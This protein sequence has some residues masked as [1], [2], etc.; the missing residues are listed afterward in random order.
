VLYWLQD[1]PR[2]YRATPNGMV[3]QEQNE[4]K[5]PKEKLVRKFWRLKLHARKHVPVRNYR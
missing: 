3:L 4:T 1:K 5:R 2:R